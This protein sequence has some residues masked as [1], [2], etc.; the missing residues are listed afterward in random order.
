MIAF[1]LEFL[2]N[3]RHIVTKLYILNK[4]ILLYDDGLD[5]DK[6]WSSLPELCTGSKKKERYSI[7]DSQE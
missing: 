5:D 4:I 6:I 2:K 1:F 3:H 7:N